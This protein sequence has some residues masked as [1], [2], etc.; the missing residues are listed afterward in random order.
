MTNTEM[1]TF[2][3]S[4]KSTVDKLREIQ[5]LPPREKAQR[6]RQAAMLLCAD[7][8]M[9]YDIIESLGFTIENIIEEADRLPEDVANEIFHKIMV[10]K[11]QLN[12]MWEAV[13]DLYTEAVKLEEI[14]EK[15][16]WEVGELVDGQKHKK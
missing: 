9:F 1:R 11:M 2:A 10:R 8:E 15:M 14:F 3:N 16:H 6:T 13:N 4:G 7:G 12:S 5:A